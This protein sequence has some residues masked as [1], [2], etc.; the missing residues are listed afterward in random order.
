MKTKDRCGKLASKPECAIIYLTKVKHFSTIS[1]MRDKVHD[2]LGLESDAATRISSRKSFLID[3]KSFRVGT[4]L[5]S[6]FLPF[7]MRGSYES[8]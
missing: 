8:N 3:A 7:S 2:F 4:R 5:R 6:A 1:H